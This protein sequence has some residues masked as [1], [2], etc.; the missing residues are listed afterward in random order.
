MNSEA[1]LHGWQHHGRKL[2]G[3][4]QEYP[5]VTEPVNPDDTTL[6]DI[7]ITVVDVVETCGPL[8]ISRESLLGE[9]ILRLSVAGEGQGITNL[10]GTLLP[11]S[12]S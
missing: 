10:P 9:V 8:P 1:F 4:Y 2:L 12:I 6:S 11:S 7:S 3:N 5:T